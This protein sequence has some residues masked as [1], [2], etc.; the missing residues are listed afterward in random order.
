MG[1]VHIRIIILTTLHAV[2]YLTVPPHYRPEKREALFKMRSDNESYGKTLFHPTSNQVSAH[3]MDDHSKYY[4]ENLL[5]LDFRIFRIRKTSQISLRAC[6]TLIEPKSGTSVNST[7]QS[8]G[9]VVPDLKR[10]MTVKS[11][12]G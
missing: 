7:T 12:V 11:Q 3:S 5:V 8:L 9:Q 6:C 1:I 4:Q 10:N 2:S